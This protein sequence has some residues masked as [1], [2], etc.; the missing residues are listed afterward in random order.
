MRH[1]AAGATKLSRQFVLREL[2]I[3]GLLT[4]VVLFASGMVLLGANLSQLRE[5]YARVQNANATLLELSAVHTEVL[6]IELTIRGYLLSGDPTFLG[7]GD[8]NREQLE[9]S[10]N[11][12][13]QLY[14]GDPQH[15]GDIG[16]LRAVLAEY[17]AKFADIAQTPRDQATARV[18]TLARA[19][20]RAPL[21]RTLAAMQAVEKKH[22]AEQVQMAD[23]KV[24]GANFLGFGIIGLAVL[25]GALGLG[26]TVACR[27]GPKPN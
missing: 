17:R 26:F 7:W 10:M 13:G 12:L 27:R 16:K 15:A 21:V 24:R 8:K 4:A 6:Q 25:V 9:Q 23:E 5:T 19:N 18:V 2:G 20:V 1:Q 3:A 14:A 11:H 22:L